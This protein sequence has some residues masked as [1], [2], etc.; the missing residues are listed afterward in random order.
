MDALTILL[1][2]T[3]KTVRQSQWLL[4]DTQECCELL[5]VV[6][7]CCC[8]LLLLLLLLLFLDIFTHKVL[9]STYIHNIGASF[10]EIVQG[11][12]YLNFEGCRGVNVH[13]LQL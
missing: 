4:G 8:L 6:V 10:R 5:V 13:I 11:K 12:Q 2:Q 9:I 7:F 1:S 3:A